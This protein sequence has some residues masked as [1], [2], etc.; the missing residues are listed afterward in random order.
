MNELLWF[1][2][3]ATGVASVLL[4]T[5]V[6]V[7]GLVTTSRRP[8]KGIRSAVVMGLHRSLSLGA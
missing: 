4:L 1:V 3:R 2:S 7:L 8:P 6:V 5:V